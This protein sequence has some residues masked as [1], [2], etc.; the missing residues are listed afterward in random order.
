MLQQQWQRAF[1]VLQ[2]TPF[3]AL[4]QQ[5]DAQVHE[6]IA[7]APS[8]APVGQVIRQVG[9]GYLL[10]GRLLRSARVVVSA[11][12]RGTT[13]IGGEQAAYDPEESP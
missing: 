2:V 8:D 9:R 4:G 13:P 3:D 1:A 10:G 6:Y 5:Y 7:S 11:G 12:L